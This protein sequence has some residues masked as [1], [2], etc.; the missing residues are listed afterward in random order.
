[1]PA[2]VRTR[3]LRI[4]RFVSLPRREG[5][6]WQGGALPLP[7]F[8]EDP[9]TGEPTR[10]SVVGWANLATGDIRLASVDTSAAADHDLALDSL[11]D[12]ALKS[13]KTREGRPARLEVADPELAAHVSRELGDAVEVALVSGLPAIEQHVESII[14]SEEDGIVAPGVLQAPGVTLDRLRAFAGAASRLYSSAIWND[15]DFEDLVLVESPAAPDGMAGFAVFPDDRAIR[16][17]DGEEAFDALRGDRQPG[18]D[19]DDGLDDDEDA[20]GDGDGA[21]DLPWRLEFVSLPELPIR[22]VAAWADGGLPVA[23]AEAYPV[24]V[25]KVGEEAFERPDAS[26]LAFLEGLATVLAETTEA[27]IDSGRWSRDAETSD[28]PQRF[29]L[30]L[31]GLLNLQEA[32]EAAGGRLSRL[33]AEGDFGSPE[34]VFAR[35][36]ESNGEALQFPAPRTA[37]E[38]AQDLVYRSITAAGRR[39]IQLLRQALDLW[40]DC[41]E[42]YL[43]LAEHAQPERALDWFRVGAAAAERVIGAGDLV[44]A[45][46]HY[47]QRR[48]TRSYLRLRF[49]MAASQMASGD[50]AAAAAAFRELLSLDAEDHAGARD[51]LLALLLEQGQDDDLTEL[52]ARFADGS[53]AW[54]YGDVLRLYRKGDKK[55]AAKA[56]LAAHRQNPLAAALLTAD[57]LGPERAEGLSGGRRMSHEMEDEAA[58]AVELLAEVW[59]STPGAVEWMVGRLRRR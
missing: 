24:A 28:G 12:F 49:G 57:V 14:Q 22:D 13:R 50:S 16:F 39:R 26:R 56:L 25:R 6:T 43:Y 34:E 33:T 5:E 54:H 19:E 9:E 51:Y 23:G 42:A 31:P 59:A 48:D 40:P 10:Q 35:V 1:M 29:R 46:G 37:E 41:Y 52:F 11:L 47:W 15:L 18:D 4:A 21:P 58:D 30:S 20:A 8:A 7:L 36:V 2:N 17:F 45:R 27:E 38:R 55:A 3:A 53:A 32:E 44:A